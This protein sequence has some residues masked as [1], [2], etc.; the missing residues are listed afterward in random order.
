[1]ATW[2]KR[3]LECL[4]S[5]HLS[6]SCPQVAQLE[7]Q[8]NVSA[9]A[10][11]ALQSAA[12]K[13]GTREQ[14]AE[15]AAKGAEQHAARRIVAQEQLIASLSDEL[16]TAAA[17]QVAFVLFRFSCA[18]DLLSSLRALCI[19]SFFLRLLLVVPMVSHERVFIII[20]LSLRVAPSSARA[21]EP[22]IPSAPVPPPL[23]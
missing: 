15:G 5:A 19:F 10:L 21:S 18:S 13:S 16:A 23:I 6:L 3:R 22:A 8:L 12:R 7:A 11:A 2:Q 9:L 1:V 4:P 17:A 20:L 14:A